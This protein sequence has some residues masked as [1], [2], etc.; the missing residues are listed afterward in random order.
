MPLSAEHAATAPAR[1]WKTSGLDRTLE[2]KLSQSSEEMSSSMS[3]M[4]L[5]IMSRSLSVS[6]C[7]C[8][9]L[10]AEGFMGLTYRQYYGGVEK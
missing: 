10:C 8:Y 7:S 4:E 5:N 3:P 9:I 2:R 1:F 6:F